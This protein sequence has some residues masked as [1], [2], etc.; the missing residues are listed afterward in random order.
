MAKA[1]PS[2]K[3]LHASLGKKQLLPVYLLQGE[4]DFLLEKGSGEILDAAVPAEHR[5]F[6]LEVVDC[7]D[8][9]ARDLMARA[10][11]MPMMGDR[12]AVVARNVDR[13]S[14]RDLELLQSYV[15]HPA[16][17]TVL[18]LIARKADL[19]KKP[20]AGLHSR[21][22]AFDFAPMSEELLPGWIAD[23]VQARGG[24]IDE[25]GADLLAAYVGS[26]LREIDN[27]I[28]KLLTFVGKGK[29]VTA[30]HVA[31]LVGFSREFTIFELQNAIG[32]GNLPRALK[33]MEHM[34]RDRYPVV[35]LMSML[36]IYFA[37]IWKLHHYLRLSSSPNRGELM[38]KLRFSP[39]VLQSY[40]DAARRYSSERVEHAFCLLA[41]ADLQTKSTTLAEDRDVLFGM[42]VQI[43]QEPQSEESAS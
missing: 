9:D 38:S 34:L 27:E 18:I 26:S 11:S 7:A 5:D 13:L 21:G 29:Q 25:E 6:N 28:E 12:R 19:R 32:Q 20:F 43:M 14:A 2:Y 15:E 37:N 31:D 16:E 17:S 22:A 41:E 35:L 30:Q 39:R 24:T 1:G 42:L 4:E 8:V 10:S 40:M 23:R 3:E 33:I 36:T